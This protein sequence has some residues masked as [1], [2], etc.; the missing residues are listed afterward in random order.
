MTTIRYAK[1]APL[2]PNPMSELPGNRNVLWTPDRE[3]DLDDEDARR[4]LKSGGSAF[5]VVEAKK[6]A[7]PRP[8]RKAA[9]RPSKARKAKTT[10]PP[11]GGSEEV[12]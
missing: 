11:E 7:T 9:P 1:S 10:T 2:G 5:E 4:L 3:V 6:A 12:A 8:P